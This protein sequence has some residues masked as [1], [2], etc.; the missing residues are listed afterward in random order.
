MD[1]ISPSLDQ[2]AQ[3]RHHDDVSHLHAAFERGHEAYWAFQDVDDNPYPSHAPEHSEWRR[4]F[5]KAEQ[6][7][8]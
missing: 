5:E 8:Q 2:P 6:T 7:D 4:G 3:G 1:K